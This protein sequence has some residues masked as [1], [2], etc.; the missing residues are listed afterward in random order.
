MLEI[1]LAIAKRYGVE[2]RADDDASRQVFTSL[3]NLA[4]H[5]EHARAR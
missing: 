3:R 2:L 1:S 4:R 5:V